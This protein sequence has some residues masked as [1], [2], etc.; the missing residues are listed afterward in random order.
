MVSR[1]SGKI[2]FTSSIAS[3]M[4]GSYQAVYNASKSFVQS[5]APALRNE[6]KLA[7]VGVKLAKA[8]KQLSGYSG[9]QGI[10]L[11]RPGYQG[12]GRRTI[13]QGS[14]R[15]PAPSYPRGRRFE[16]AGYIGQLLPTDA[17]GSAANRIPPSLTELGQVLVRLPKYRVDCS[18]NL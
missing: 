11:A 6:L 16:P 5:F 1:G 8:G 7:A 9:F 18:S 3:T 17:F 4:P 2:L 10:K 13:P 15:S 14:V 12:A